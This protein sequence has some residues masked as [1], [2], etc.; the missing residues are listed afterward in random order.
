MTPTTSKPAPHKP[1][2]WSAYIAATGT[3]YV[4]AAD[5]RLVC[6]MSALVTDEQPADLA[7][8]VAAPRLLAE[9]RRL[10][11]YLESVGYG[12]FAP[13]TAFAAAVKQA[14]GHQ[15]PDVKEEKEAP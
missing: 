5:G 9:G 15:A 2:P 10:L 13:V 11:L 7:L 4:H 12:G 3:Q 6:T 1:G 14:S 8:V